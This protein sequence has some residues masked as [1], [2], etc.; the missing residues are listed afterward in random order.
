MYAITDL[1]PL[2]FSSQVPD[3]SITV[4]DD[5]EAE[6]MI[7]TQ[8]VNIFSAVHFPYGHNINIHDVR[9]V[10]EYYLRDRKSRDEGLESSE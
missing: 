9:S 4:S 2:M 5:N 6:V 8:D 10:I 1:Q 7:D 3:I